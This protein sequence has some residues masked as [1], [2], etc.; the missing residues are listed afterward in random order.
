MTSGLLARAEELLQSGAPAG[1][2]NSARLAAFLA[3]QEVESLIDARCRDVT[4]ADVTGATM[5]A[6]IA[7]LRALDETATG[8]VLAAA[9]YELSGYCHH[10]AYELSPAASQVRGV[11]A[12]VIEVSA[13]PAP[14]PRP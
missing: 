1:A 9:W 8:R 5:K 11:V 6:R 4:G 14:E 3:R 13:S 10:H 7:V 2:G 12:A